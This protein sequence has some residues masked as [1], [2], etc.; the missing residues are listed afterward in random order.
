MHSQVGMFIPGV[1]VDDDG[2]PGPGLNTHAAKQLHHGCN[3]IVLR[4]ASSLF[5]ESILKASI[6]SF[7]ALLQE[8]QQSETSLPPRQ[9]FQTHRLV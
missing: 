7:A 2:P 1:P 4:A 8:L 9:L 6:L 3:N 5:P